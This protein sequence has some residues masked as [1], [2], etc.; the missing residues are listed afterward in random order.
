MNKT[1]D[2]ANSSCD[3]MREVSW[4]PYKLAELAD[5]CLGKMLDRKKNK[6]EFYPYLANLNVR[7]GIINLEDLREMR[8]ESIYT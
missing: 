6:G 4:K 8:F 3:I 1:I 2:G 5:M 7:W